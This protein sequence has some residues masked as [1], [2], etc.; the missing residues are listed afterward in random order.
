[1]DGRR[2]GLREGH[3]AGLKEGLKEG[4]QAE[5]S[6]VVRLIAASDKDGKITDIKRLISDPSS[7][8]ELYKKYG[9]E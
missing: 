2:E 9:I 1:M 8:E 7:L 5:Q 3:S 6:N 4:Q